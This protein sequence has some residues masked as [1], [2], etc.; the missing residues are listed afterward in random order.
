MLVWPRVRDGNWDVALLDLET[1]RRDPSRPP[2]L[3]EDS[4]PVITHP[5][6]A[7]LIIY[8][9]V[10]PESG[11]VLRVMGADG[12]RGPGTALLALPDGCDLMRRPAI[13]PGRAAGGD[14]RGICADPEQPACSNVLEPDGTLV[15]RLHDL[16]RMGEPTVTPDGSAV[17]YWR[18]DVGDR[19]R[20]IA[21]CDR[22]RRRVGPGPAHPRRATTVRMPT[23]PSS[24]DGTQIAFRRMID[25]E[26]VWS[27][28]PRS[29]ARS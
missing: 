13:H 9:Q 21:L 4:F 17:V 1:G 6:T 3:L 25:G 5:E 15:R 12:Q 23:P 29:T 8:N 27:S 24:P 18:N 22:H 10:D 14:V 7:G 16:G 28:P 20:R 2:I 19:G 11:P 26:R